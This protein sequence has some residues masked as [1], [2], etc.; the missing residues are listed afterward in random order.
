MVRFRIEVMVALLMVVGVACSP[1]S[2]DLKIGDKAPAL[3]IMEWVKGAPVD[4]ARDAKKKIHVIEFWAVWCPPCKMSVPLL[5]EMQKKHSKDLTIIGV[6][7]PDAGRNT[8]SAVKRFV[9][10]R[11]D[12]MDYTVALDTGKTAVNYM[13]ASGAVGI[14]QAYVVDREGIIVWMGSPLEPAAGR[15][16]RTIGRRYV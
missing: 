7:E 10:E 12:E 1:A 15:D 9:Q 11:G 2:A 14:P 5:T 6:T 13:E 16:H 3:S 4:L 8:P